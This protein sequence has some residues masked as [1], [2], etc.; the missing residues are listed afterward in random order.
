MKESIKKCI[1]IAAATVVTPVYSATETVTNYIQDIGGSTIASFDSTSTTLNWRQKHHAYGDRDNKG[2]LE[3]PLGYASHA[4]NKNLNLVYMKRRWYDPE[5]GR[6]MS[7][8]PNDLQITHFNT[9][10]RYMY[11]NNNP[12]KYLDP[13]GRASM[14]QWAWMGG[15]PIDWGVAATIET[16]APYV[17]E[18]VV[19]GVGLGLAVS[20]G[21]AGAALLGPPAAS[22]YLG[23]SELAVVGDASITAGAAVSELVASS[24]VTAR[25]GYLIGAP[26]YYLV[27]GAI[28][29]LF[30]GPPELDGSKMDELAYSIWYFGSF[31]YDFSVGVCT[32][33]DQINNT[34]D[35][36]ENNSSEN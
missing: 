17:A 4:E 29:N 3:N 26:H 20:A 23:I 2:P 21:V 25:Y 9:Y 16:E 30:P 12:Y 22:A 36:I 13:D 6:F 7:V 15:I 33:C 32:I 11:A 28:S 18:G 35:Y 19:K 5:I 14:E 10:N 34:L 31:I 27:P 1:V 24:L 8:D